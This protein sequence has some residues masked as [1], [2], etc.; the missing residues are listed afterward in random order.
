MVFRDCTVFEEM[1]KNNDGIGECDIHCP[2]FLPAD[3]LQQSGALVGTYFQPRYLLPLTTLFIGVLLLRAQFVRKLSNVQISL[4]FVLV[5]AANS[6]A[7]YT[8]IKRY[9]HGLTSSEWN[10]D[11]APTWWWDTGISPMLNWALG[12]VG[13]TI[14]AWFTLF[15]FFNRNTRAIK[16]SNTISATASD[17]A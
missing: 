15:V 10:L 8:N 13:F 17:L 12:S 3:C 9:T 11:R 5:S 16:E 2:Y 4:I 6:L 14:F 1:V 7:L